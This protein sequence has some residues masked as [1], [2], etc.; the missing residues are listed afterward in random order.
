MVR[1]L[2]GPTPGTRVA[3]AVR[4]AAGPIC[5]CVLALCAAS[6][7]SA[8]SPPPLTI[9]TQGA[10]NDN[11]D[12]FISPNGAKAPYSNGVEITNTQ[13]EVIWFHAAPAGQEDTDF[14]TQTYEGQPVLTFWQGTGFGG[15][16]KGTDYIY[17]DHFEQIAAVNAGNG[18]S[19]DGHEF[20][21]TPQ[22]TALILAY[23]TNKANLSGIGGS[24]EQTVVNGIVQEIDIGTG[25][26][27]FQ[28]DSEGNV[29]FGA[30][31]E[32]LPQSPSTPWEWFHINAVKLDTN[33]NLLIDAR[34][35]WAFYEVNRTTGEVLWT[36]GG[37]DSTFTEQAALG[38]TLDDAGFIT[39]WQ[40]DPEP[41]GNDEYTVFDNEAAVGPPQ[42]P[43][44][45][46]VTIQ[47]NQ[48]TDTATLVNSY[49]QP[50]DAQAAS[51]GN[52]QT[53]ANGD[54]F[55][56]WGALPYITE[57][58]AADETLWEA[59][60]PA[61]VNSYRAYRLPW[62]SGTTVEAS[63]SPST[64]T[65]GSAV[66]YSATVSSA[67]S[68]TPTGTVTFSVG[69]TTLCT[70]ESLAGGS[71]S[72]SASNAPVGNDTVTATYSGDANFASSAGTAS[73]TVDAAPA[74]TSANKT[75]FTVGTA[76]SFTVTATGFPAP[77]V[78]ESGTL[79]G[80]VT[81]AGGVLSGTPTQGGVYAITFT[82]SNG[83][84]ANA[85]QSFTL[86][87][88]APPLITSPA[89]AE[90]E[91]G[92]AGSFKVT[93]TGTPAPTI[94][95]WGNLPAG[96]T[97]ASGLLSGKPSGYGSFELT[98]TASNGIGNPSYQKFLLWVLGL[99]VTTASLPEAVTGTPYSEQLTARGGVQPYR[100][101]VTGGALPQGLKLS[102]T[103]VISGTPKATATTS[104]FAATVT[105][106]KAPKAEQQTATAV[107]TLN[108]L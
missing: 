4:A 42:L 16:A 96:V 80:G 35:T 63:A 85:V 33:G 66:T 2:L 57:S 24:E 106:P 62:L 74:I 89:I 93:A 68:G 27:L 5:A 19:A 58:N 64:S 102:K 3:A 77:S 44:S 52:S 10:S 98:F 94:T 36:L 49:N 23:A 97:F 70:T 28:W 61:G 8:A 38:Q 55:T 71:G 13:G 1:T 41:V 47:L 43:Y 73:L 69:A 105:D 20:L 92:V 37:K 21:I 54:L 11:G 103:G 56:G 50:Q 6:A 90:F 18:L 17:N 22:N 25:Q 60:F 59:Q 51:Q 31:E 79:P 30:S 87:V 107:L 86:T 91:Q 82:A 75:T 72:C 99:H 12:I 53:T 81:F 9:L 45:R 65:V 14:R 7:A 26:V 39:A 104:T 101:S 95:E 32:A 34:N 46:V 88:D 108:V 29:P 76:G 15:L 40:H 67:A 78:S 100:W 84:G 83:V 48:L